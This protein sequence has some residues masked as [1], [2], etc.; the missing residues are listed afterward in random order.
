MAGPFS[1]F[2]GHGLRE[3]WFRFFQG[4]LSKHRRP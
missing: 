1:F 3:L 4:L 2:Y